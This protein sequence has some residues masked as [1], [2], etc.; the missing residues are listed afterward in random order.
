MPASAWILLGAILALIAKI[1]D[2]PATTTHAIAAISTWML[3]HPS[4][5]AFIAALALWRLTTHHGPLRHARA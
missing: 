3:T 1:P 2:G 4:G 5:L